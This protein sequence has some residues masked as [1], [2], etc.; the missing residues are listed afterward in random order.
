MGLDMY[1][2]A[3][4][5]LASSPNWESERDRQAL[6]DV[7]KI[8]GAEEVAPEEE[9]RSRS[10]TIKIEIAYWRK[11]NHIHKFFV[12]QCANGEDNCQDTYV[13]VETLKELMTRCERVL[14]NHD[15]AE[16]LLP[17]QSGF[18]FGGTDYGE[19]YY[20]VLENTLKILKKIIPEIESHNDWDIYYCASW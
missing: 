20:E 4:K 14:E 8:M 17:T 18:F 13:S 2:Y 1:L 15:L 19:Y 16:E 6:K 3:E 11:A 7:I 5:Y 9:H 10:A 12:D